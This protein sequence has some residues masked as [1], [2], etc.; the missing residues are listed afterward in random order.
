MFHASIPHTAAIH[1]HRSGGVGSLYHVPG[2][3][4]SLGWTTGSA[5]GGGQ[6]GGLG[7]FQKASSSRGSG[8]AEQ[9][10]AHRGSMFLA[11]EMAGAKVLG[12][13]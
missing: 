3:D 13:A 6:R 9:F 2:W 4:Q 1:I 5:A 11:K 12:Q 7:W 10:K 8:G